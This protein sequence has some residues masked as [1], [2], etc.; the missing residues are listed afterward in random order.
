MKTMIPR[1]W[2]SAV[3]A[4]LCW[5]CAH[6]ADIEWVTLPGGEFTMGRGTEGE[7]GPAHK[8]TL[9]PFQMARTKVTVGQYKACV[10]AGACAA[11]A[12]DGESTFGTWGK[13]GRENYPVNYVTWEQAGAFSKW[14]GGRLPTEAEWEFAARGT[15]SRPFPWGD[16]A[17]SCVTPAKALADAQSDE[18]PPLVPVCST[19]ACN[20]PAGLCDMAGEVREWVADFYYIGYPADH[21]TDPRAEPPKPFTHGAVMR[22]LRGSSFSGQ[23]ISTARGSFPPSSAIYFT[24]FRPAR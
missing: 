12:C 21:Q 19:P 4:A 8:V 18:E 13:P 2:M 1:L 11:P 9:S 10:D 16:E 20:T 15:E 23:N 3:V 22:V 6:S 7:E 5:N 24:G 14:V 17:A